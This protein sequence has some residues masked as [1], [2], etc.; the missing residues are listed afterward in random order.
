MD[1]PGIPFPPLVKP[2]ARPQFLPIIRRGVRNGCALQSSAKLAEPDMIDLKAIDEL[3]RRVSALVP[4]GMKEAGAE[5]EANLKAT[6]QA[7]LARLDLVTREEFE[8]QRA[9]LLRTR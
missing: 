7:G 8:V 6:L 4:P 9:V 3:A 1:G 5:F 2:Q